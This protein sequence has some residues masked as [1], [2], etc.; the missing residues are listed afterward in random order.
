MRAAAGGGGVMQMLFASVKEGFTK[1]QVED[2]AR[3]WQGALPCQRFWWWLCAWVRRARARASVFVV[4]ELRPCA[5][6]NACAHAPAALLQTNGIQ[7][8]FFAI[9]EKQVLITEDDGK[10]LE[11]RRCACPYSVATAMLADGV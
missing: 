2:L 4:S 10:V 6:V 1:T 7:T 8:K 3:R 11:V 5:R 9:D